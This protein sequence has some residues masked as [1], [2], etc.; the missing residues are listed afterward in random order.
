MNVLFQPIK[1]E[2][3]PVGILDAVADLKRKKIV[4]VA[5]FKG[6]LGVARNT[7]NTGRDSQLLRELKKHVETH[8]N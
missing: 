2:G 4:S 7:T 5:K 3:T 6:W 1:I 8:G